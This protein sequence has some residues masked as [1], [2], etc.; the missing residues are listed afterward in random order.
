P[1][2]P[3]VLRGLADFVPAADKLLGKGT[4]QPGLH[5]QMVVVPPL[6]PHHIGRYV[7]GKDTPVFG[8]NLG[9]HCYPVPFPGINLNDGA[10]PSSPGATASPRS[11]PRH[12]AS[13]RS[14][15]TGS[16]APQAHTTAAQGQLAG[17][18]T[19]GELVRELTGM[20]LGRS[21]SLIP[22]WGS[23]L[24]APLFRGATVSLRTRA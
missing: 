20:A 13:T 10:A 18:P 15:G 2:F 9:P 12:A 7:A 24:T 8:D 16:E 5:V 17:S 21:P 19:E 4:N 1:E 22:E 11:T 14:H 23:L 3:C 6:G